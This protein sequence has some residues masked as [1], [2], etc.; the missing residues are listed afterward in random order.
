M[1]AVIRFKDFKN[2]SSLSM[3]VNLVSLK[4]FYRA[5]I[6]FCHRATCH[7]CMS[8]IITLRNSGLLGKGRPSPRPR[9]RFYRGMAIFPRPR[10][11]PRSGGQFLGLPRP[12]S[13]IDSKLLGLGEI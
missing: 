8:R 13:K 1:S 11:R 2:K 10:P 5:Y 12:R 3:V 4:G 9:P 7:I 6:F